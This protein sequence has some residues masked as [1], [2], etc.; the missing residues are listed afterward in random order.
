[1]ESKTIK[2]ALASTSTALMLLSA[3]VVSANSSNGWIKAPDSQWHYAV[4]GT[5][6]AN[7]WVK[8]GNDWYYIGKKGGS[9]AVMATNQWQVQNGAWYYL[10]N[11]GKMMTNSWVKDGTNWYYVGNDG[12][13]VT[14]TWEKSGNDWYYLGSNGQMMTNN[15]VKSVNDWYYLGGNGAMLKGVNDRVATAYVGGHNYGFDKDGKM[16]KNTWKQDNAGNWL[17]FQANGEALQASGNINH[18]TS[19]QGH[20]YDFGPDGRM[21]TGEQDADMGT[22]FLNDGSVKC[23]Q[24]GE[25]VSDAWIRHGSRWE[26]AAGAFLVK[27]NT[28]G[29]TIRTINGKTYA[30]DRGGLTANGE[31]NREVPFAGSHVKNVDELNAYLSGVKDQK[32]KDQIKDVWQFNKDH[33]LKDNVI[34]QVDNDGVVTGV[35]PHRAESA[36]K[37]NNR[38]GQ[39]KVGI[40][41]KVTRRQLGI[42]LMVT[43][44]QQATQTIKQANNATQ[45]GKQLAKV[46][47]AKDAGFV[48]APNS[49]HM[50]A[51]LDR[52]PQVAAPTTAN[53]ATTKTQ[54]ATVDP[55]KGNLHPVTSTKAAPVTHHQEQVAQKQQQMKPNAKNDDQATKAED[56]STVNTTTQ[57]RNVSKDGDYTKVT[58]ITRDR[59]GNIVS[60]KEVE[61]RRVHLV[62]PMKGRSYQQPGYAKQT[63]APKAANNNNQG[64][65]ANDDNSALAQNRQRINHI[66]AMIDHVESMLRDLERMLGMH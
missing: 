25:M 22:V 38:G 59:N 9:S 33:S 41:L 1:M 66:R 50:A 32:L 19:V 3:G 37:A 52:A 63:A 47:I 6:V 57:I 30:F 21:L 2:T 5:N 40:P 28:D 35:K 54:H 26:Y 46:T 31:G 12:K 16:V 10:G 42:P 11:D 65:N 39:Y 13:M 48:P 15:W 51:P 36:I 62:E 24:K 44:Q 34:L 29:D 55:T 56:H 27:G 64:N 20:A 49:A 17:F 8:S 18:V 60:V 58:T 4:N 43:R 7:T 23:Y 14:N 53:T 61:T 45:D